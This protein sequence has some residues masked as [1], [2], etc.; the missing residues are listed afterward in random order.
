MIIEYTFPKGRRLLLLGDFER[1]AEVLGEI[2]I[3]T[4]GAE[5]VLVDFPLD[6]L[7]ARV[8]KEDYDI[9]LLDLNLA[10]HVIEAIEAVCGKGAEGKLAVITGVSRDDELYQR[11]E[12]IRNAHPFAFTFKP[13]GMEFVQNILGKIGVTPTYENAQGNEG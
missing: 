7:T 4:Y 3:K 1:T 11:M 2:F 12:A 9:V 13:F 10:T 5:A 8:L 6:E